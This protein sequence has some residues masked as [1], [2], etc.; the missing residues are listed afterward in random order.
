MTPGCLMVPYPRCGTFE[1][2]SL[3]VIRLDVLDIKVHVNLVY[4]V[5]RDANIPGCDSL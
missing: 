1:Y 4:I 3:Q 2:N 5:L